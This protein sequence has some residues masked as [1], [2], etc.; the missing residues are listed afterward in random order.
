[1]SLRLGWSR[2]RD[3]RL[4][5][6]DFRFERREKNHEKAP[7]RV[8]PF[9]TC[10]IRYK[11]GSGGL[12]SSWFAGLALVAYEIQERI[13]LENGYPEGLRGVADFLVAI[14]YSH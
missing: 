1:M 2:G 14:E 4:S 10:L 5:I 13:V 8:S 6:Y 9:V 12:K 3:L 11:A 7:F